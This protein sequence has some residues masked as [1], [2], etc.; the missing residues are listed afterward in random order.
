MVTLKILYIDDNP[1]PAL[2]KYLDNYQNEACEFDYSDI[3]FNPDKGYESLINNSEV[4]GAN[5]IIIDSRL[6]ENRNAT[7]GKFTGEE[8]KIILKKYFPF[9]EVIVISQNEID[10]DYETI[11][12]YAPSSGKTPKEY[13]DEKLPELLNRSVRNI[14]EA[15]KIASEMERN[16]SWEKVMIEKI[17]NSVNGQGKFDEL[18][19]EDIDKVISM[20]C[21]LQEKIE[22]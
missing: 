8:F 2:A 14:F 7:T 1:E 9:I 22:G 5:I 17:V 13:Y 16:T 15:R 20:F 3:K 18:T 12:K 19:K 11:S 6:F 21:E 4:K 10:Y